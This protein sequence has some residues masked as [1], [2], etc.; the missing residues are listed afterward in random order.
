[1]SFHYTL[2]PSL[3]IPKVLPILEKLIKLVWQIGSVLDFT[4]GIDLHLLSGGGRHLHR[5]LNL[6]DPRWRNSKPHGD[7]GKS[8]PAGGTFFLADRS[9]FRA[10]PSSMLTNPALFPTRIGAD[11][12]LPD[13]D[14]PQNVQKGLPARPQRVKRRGV[15]FGTLSL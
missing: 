15:R 7:Q 14:A 5:L 9:H 8:Y 11:G 2:H 4:P 3:Y 1:M 13:R 12:D 10:M 6:L